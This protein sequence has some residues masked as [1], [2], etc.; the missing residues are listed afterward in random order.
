MLSNEYLYYFKTPT[1]PKWTGF[2]QL[3]FSSFRVNNSDPEAKGMKACFKIITPN[4]IF[5]L[6]SDS[7]EEVNN[8]VQ[9]LTAVAAHLWE[10]ENRLAKV[11]SIDIWEKWGIVNVIFFCRVE[12][13][14]LKLMSSKKDG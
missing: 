11:F 14:I 5:Y 2:I 13:E 7:Q 3:L 1:D 8:W 12:E 4:R 6:G 10:E 9:S